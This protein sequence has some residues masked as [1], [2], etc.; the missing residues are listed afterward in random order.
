MTA[1]AFQGEHIR[2]DSPKYICLKF[3]LMY[4]LSIGLKCKINV[5][6][7][8]WSVVSAQS[9]GAAIQPK[10]NKQTKNNNRASFGHDQ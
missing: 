9:L 3:T 8:Q 2:I 5:G 1:T 4:S 6:V 10:N 7:L